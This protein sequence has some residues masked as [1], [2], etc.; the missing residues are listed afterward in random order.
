MGSLLPAWAQPELPNSV[1]SWTTP[2]YL[3]RSISANASMQNIASIFVRFSQVQLE[4]DW[5]QTFAGPQRILA[6]GES[7]EWEFPNCPI[8][9]DTWLGNH[10]FV[11]SFS[12]SWAEAAGNWSREN[13]LS[14]PPT[15]FLVEPSP[16]PGPGPLEALTAFLSSPLGISAFLLTMT[17]VVIVA[18]TIMAPWRRKTLERVGSI[19]LSLIAFVILWYSSGKAL[20]PWW[21]AAVVWFIEFSMIFI[22]VISIPLVWLHKKLWSESFGRAV[23]TAREL[24]PGAI[25]LSCFMLSFAVCTLGFLLPFREVLVTLVPLLQ[26]A[27]PLLP[28]SFTQSAF[29]NSYTGAILAIV[30]PG[31]AILFG[32]RKMREWNPRTGRTTLEILQVIFYASVILALCSW[33]SGSA[34]SGELL[35]NY[36]IALVLF[37]LPGSLIAPLAICLQIAI[38][39]RRKE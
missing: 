16:Q 23:D 26:P 13:R 10:T 9:E 1:T 35:E 15:Y 37:V 22:A 7:Y 19:V 36:R 31:P 12:L 21:V 34:L 39:S 33:A 28:V 24:S 32:L 38:S 2:V 20:Q 3:G 30:L 6:P 18:L 11:F 29:L 17:L 8:P 14:L 25:G 27:A 4:F 5:N